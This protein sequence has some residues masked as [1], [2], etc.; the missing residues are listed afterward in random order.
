MGLNFW[1]FRKIQHDGRCPAIYSCDLPLVSGVIWD[2]WFGWLVCWGWCCQTVLPCEWYHVL[3]KI[4]GKIVSMEF[5]VSTTFVLS[6]FKVLMLLSPRKTVQS[7]TR[8]FLIHRK[9]W[10]RWSSMPKNKAFFFLL[11]KWFKTDISHNCNLLKILCIACRWCHLE[12]FHRGVQNT[13]VSAWI[14][15]WFK[16][17]IFIV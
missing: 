15:Y 6:S 10:L 5:L 7:G 12:Y 4:L 2:L 11:K 14:Q 17:S 13:F 1:K 16:R 3:E 9:T 8:I